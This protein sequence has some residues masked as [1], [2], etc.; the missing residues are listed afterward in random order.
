MQGKFC[1]NCGQKAKTERITISLL[2]HDLFHFFTHIESGFLFTTLRMFT[3]PGTVIKEYVEG[4]RIRY[5]RPVSYFLIWVA[6]W[7]LLL[8]AFEKLFGTDTV[9][10]RNHYFS[11]ATDYAFRNLNIITGIMLPINAFYLFAIAMHRYYNYFE[12]FVAALYIQGTIFTMQVFFGIACLVYYLITGSSVNLAISDVLKFICVFGIC[13]HLLSQ[14][15]LKYRFLRMVIVVIVSTGT[16]LF[17]R[18]Y[19]LSLLAGNLF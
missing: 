8:F 13:F 7:A 19:G 18:M 11:N 14:Y 16:F 10:Y 6:T 17:W 12:C 5:Q 4:K 9:I 3:A 1:Y 2:W 15:T